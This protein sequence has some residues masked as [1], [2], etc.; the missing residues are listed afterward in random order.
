[1]LDG[2]WTLERVSVQGAKR[3]DQNPSWGEGFV[4]LSRASG[5]LR[6]G[7]IVTSVE[8]VTRAQVSY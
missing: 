1:M 6:N 8:C 2:Q 7:H 3:L 4:I 5:I